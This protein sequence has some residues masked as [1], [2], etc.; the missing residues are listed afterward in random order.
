MFVGSIRGKTENLD[1]Y[2]II[3]ES[4]QKLGCNVT[5]DHVL[6]NSQNDLDKMTSEDNAAFHKKILKNIKLADIV[7]SE[8]TYQ[9]LS[10][11]Y[12][13]S[14][15]IEREEKPT[16]IFYKSTTP[17]PNLF[18]TLTASDKLF[19]AKYS[20]LDELQELV[21]EY[22]A[23]AKEQIDTRFNFFVSPAIERYLTWIAKKRKLPRSVFLRKLI[24]DSM[25][26]DKAFLSDGSAST[27]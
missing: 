12:L 18:P 27:S 14:Y 3:I 24:E 21:S 5:A 13:L 6:K 11:G 10:V 8:C 22:L 23:Y 16:I 17:E 7:I 2:K 9:S 20:S 19:V 26:K 1:A 15:A 4:M 25:S